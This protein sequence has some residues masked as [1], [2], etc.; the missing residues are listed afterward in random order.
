MYRFNFTDQINEIIVRG[1]KNRLTDNELIVR[2]I[3][4]FL[5]SKRWKD[6]IDGENYYKGKHDILHRK[7]MII[8]ANGKLEAVGNL[9]NNHI[10]DNQYKKMVN[11]KVN[12]LLGQPITVQSDNDAY[13]KTVKVFFNKNFMRLIKNVGRDSLNGGLGW[14]FLH[15]DENGEF[16]FKRL[17]PYEIIPG[18]KDEEHTVLD[19]AIRIYEVIVFEGRNEKVVRKVEV[20]DNAGVH[21]FVLDG[22][23]LIAD[24]KPHEP[25][26]TVLDGD[27]QEPFNWSKIPLI[28]FKFNPDEIPLIRNVKSLQDGLNLILS[29]FQNNMEED[30]RNTILVLVNYDGEDLEEF[31]KNL[32]QFGAVKLKTVDGTGGD[33]RTLQIEVNAENYKAILEIFKK[34]IIENA[35][36]YDAK[37]DRLGGNANQL[38]IMSMYSDIDLDANEM[39]TE[40]QA[41]FEELLFF[42]NLHL[43]NTGAGDFEGEQIDVIFNRD[44]LISETD[45]ITNINNSV[46]I[47]SEETLIAQHPWVDDPQLELARKEAEAQKEVDEYKDVFP[48]VENKIGPKEGEVNEDSE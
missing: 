32:A 25:Y 28:P 47:L 3:Q 18:W 6:M 20:Y 1:A 9:P 13:A 43:A 36:G 38:N 14:L 5:A 42:I 45:I 12:Y 40:Y 35:M 44:I 2:E 34:A 31:R 16:T 27:V 23:R 33:L 4:R 30:T 29:N 48:G 10:V 39:E 15:Y 17:K 41:S 46:G 8:G 37:D 26:F 19:Y 22:S 24:E 7:R 21:R 11:Q